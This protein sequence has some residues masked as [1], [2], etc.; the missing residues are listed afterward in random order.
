MA[1]GQ[2]KKTL[3]TAI[4]SL[5]CG[6]LF[7]IP[8]LGMLSGLAA[9]VLGIIALVYISGNKETLKGKGLAIAGIIL[10]G[11]GL[12]LVPIVFLLAALIVP[13]LSGRSEQVR[14]SA[15]RADIQANIATALKLYELDNGV[16]P[17]TDEGLDALINKSVSAPN[18]NGPYLVRKPV[19]PWGREYIYYYPG[20]YNEEYD[21]YSLGPD[22]VE[23][24]DDVTN[25]Q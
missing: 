17:A 12:I 23:S 16:F 21:L 19:D 25:W 20:D 3:G 2:N 6:C 5:V 1:E 14:A 4:A 24:V 22:G 7:L 9:V 11:I 10:G 13:R 8:L 15:A 18:W